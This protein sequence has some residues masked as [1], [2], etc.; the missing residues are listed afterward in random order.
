MRSEHTVSMTPIDSA[1]YGKKLTGQV[2]EVA[3]EDLDSNSALSSEEIFGKDESTTGL[4]SYTQREN[5]RGYIRIVKPVLNYVLAGAQGTVLFRILGIDSKT[6]KDIMGFTK[7]YN[8]KKQSFEYIDK[9]PKDA[10]ISDYLVGPEVLASYCNKWNQLEA[11]KNE[12]IR[13]MKQEC[14]T[15]SAMDEDVGIVKEYPEGISIKLIDSLYLT[16]I[17]SDMLKEKYT[18]YMLQDMFY[19]LACKNETLQI[20]RNTSKEK[21]QQILMYNIAVVPVAFRREMNGRQHALTKMYGAIKRADSDLRNLLKDTHASLATYVTLYEALNT[22]AN[23]VMFAHDNKHTNEL[24]LAEKLSGKKGF[25]RKSFISK[26]SDYTA[27]AVVICDPTL[28]LHEIALPDNIIAKIFM[29]DLMLKLKDPTAI[30]GLRDKSVKEIVDMMEQYRVYDGLSVTLNRAPT[31]HRLSMLAYD[32]KRTSAHAIKVNTLLNEGYNLDHD[33]DTTG[34]KRPITPGAIEDV[35]GLLH[36]RHNLFK[37]ADGKCTLTPRLD[38]I[39]G[40]YKLTYNYPLTSY[41]I[42]YNTKEELWRDINKQVLKVWDTVVFN[43]ERSTAGK[44]YLAEVLSNKHVYTKD[45]VVD[46]KSIEKIVESIL[47]EYDSNDRVL[48]LL[49]QLSTIGFRIA[50]LYPAKLTILTNF[51]LEHAHKPFKKFH[52]EIE[53]LDEA[54]DLGFCTADDYNLEF[55]AHLEV[56]KKYV[57]SAAIESIEGSDINPAVLMLNGLYMAT[58]DSY[59]LDRISDDEELT[60]IDDDLELYDL[61]IDRLITVNDTIIFKGERCLAGRKLVGLE[62][63]KRIT[64]EITP[65]NIDTIYSEDIRVLGLKL[66]KIFSDI[67]IEDKILKY[68]VYTDTEALGALYELS[69]DEYTINDEVDDE[70]IPMY[71]SQQELEVDILSGK[72]RPGTVIFYQNTSE[73][74]VAGRK[75]LSLVSGKDIF[76]QVDEYSINTFSAEK[77][78]PY[79]KKLSAKF[80]SSRVELSKYVSE[81]F[82]QDSGTVAQTNGFIDIVQ[83]GAR[84]K[85]SNLVQIFMFKGQI[86]KANGNPFATIIENSFVTQLYPLEHFVAAYGSRKGVIAKS[87]MPAKTGYLERQLW[88]SPEDF[89]ITTED[90]GTDDGLHLTLADIIAEK[91]DIDSDDESKIKDAK[92]ELKRIIV[93]RYIL[94]E[95]DK[96]K[97]NK[98]GKKE[99]LP[100]KIGKE[101][102]D[103]LIT[104]ELAD[105]IL[106]KIGRDTIVNMRSPIKCKNPCCAKCYGIDLT[107]RSK[108]VKGLPIGFIASESIGEPGTQLTLKAFQK[109]G[110]ASRNDSEKTESERLYSKFAM[111]SI[112]DCAKHPEYDPVAWMDGETE[113]KPI[114]R[115]FNYVMIKGSARK[116]KLYAD[117]EVKEV[118]KK[119]EPMCKI[120]GDQDIKEKELFAGIDEAQKFLALSTYLIFASVA[121]VNFKHFETVVAALRM[122][123]VL[124][125]KGKSNI[126]TLVPY[127]R[128]EWCKKNVKETEIEY[129][130]ILAGVGTVPL[131]RENCLC[132]V[133]MENVKRG[134]R[135]STLIGNQDDLS[136][137]FN[138]MVLGLKPKIGKEYNPNFIQDRIM[139]ERQRF[140]I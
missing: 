48:D 24:A 10:R 50:K 3:L 126:R 111:T 131:I 45:M 34:V 26:R 78:I 59:R 72:I 129:K 105:E 2:H 57:E 116:V 96:Y 14:F 92:K 81:D 12:I 137:P 36:A 106:S 13:M 90:C 113:I 87:L 89:I 120:P 58:K 112:T 103:K 64:E 9:V 19:I 117:V 27:R 119:G 79:G 1:Y 42:N 139:Y 61:I 53:E 74:Y 132:S 84:G 125:T 122:R 56:L 97:T 41:E 60:S 93:G 21:L 80:K 82:R 136:N 20:I 98:D 37:P 134:L 124:D 11:V 38:M 52:E 121:S 35:E 39:Y 135:R 43:G 115:E 109:G 23:N 69:K 51:N 5:F 62:A 68:R 86:A 83:S 67:D 73:R 18:V 54:D 7:L 31:L 33:G 128:T 85:A 95:P 30:L 66:S 100:K 8:I 22:A 40:L 29:H 118:V 123:I 75:L 77:L 6:A 70:D 32:I 110:L 76:R 49:W 25:V 138:A 55:D 91:K 46:S 16:N 65:D 99:L 133:L 101:Y 71:H 88:H 44:A 130:D 140:R 63:G 4:Y 28:K 104:K 102:T 47:D 15:K 114:D 94:P 127:T 17:N 108:A 107:I